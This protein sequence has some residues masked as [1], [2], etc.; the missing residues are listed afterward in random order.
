[1][2]VQLYREGGSL[3]LSIPTAQGEM[4]AVCDYGQLTE[5]DKGNPVT[6]SMPDPHPSVSFSRPTGERPL[7]EQEQLARDHRAASDTQYREENQDQQFLDP[8]NSGPESKTQQDSIRG[9]G[10]TAQ[11][12]MTD[13][14]LRGV[15]FLEEQAAQEATANETAEETSAERPAASLPDS[16]ARAARDAGTR[17]EPG[18]QGADR[19]TTQRTAQGATGEG[20]SPNPGLQAGERAQAENTKAQTRASPDAE[21]AVQAQADMGKSGSKPSAPR[22][23]GKK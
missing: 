15:E 4:K 14:E 3:K 16:D 5:S 19:A 21:R 17:L 22:Y 20:Q 1:M 8:P 2:Q 18:V 23:S 6:L 12:G 11:I 10:A 7:Y 13:R 9:P